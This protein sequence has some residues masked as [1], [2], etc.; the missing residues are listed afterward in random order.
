M[1]ASP[2]VAG[3]DT[4]KLIGI[5]ARQTVAPRVLSIRGFLTPHALGTLWGGTFL[6]LSGLF[7]A[8]LLVRVLD[9]N[10]ANA[11]FLMLSAAV[12]LNVFSDFGQRNT[13]YTDVAGLRDEPLREYIRSTYVRRFALGLAVF[14]MAVGLA[15]VLHVNTLLTTIL[16]AIMAANSYV[17]DPGIKILCG[18]SLGYLEVPLSAIDRVLVLAGLL[19]M[20]LI[21]SASLDLVLGLYVVAGLLRF[22]GAATAVR[23]KILGQESS[24]SVSSRVKTSASS[25]ACHNQPM[26]FRRNHFWAGI[27]LLVT[28]LNLRLPVLVLPLVN[29]EHHAAHMGILMALCQSVL[30]V[31]TVVSRVWFPQILQ[32]TNGTRQLQAL[33]TSQMLF[34]CLALCLAAGLLATIV[35]CT[36][37]PHI[38]KILH[39][40][41]AARPELLRLAAIAI[42]LLC[43]GQIGRLLATSAGVARNLFLPVATGTV[44]GLLSMFFLAQT[45]GLPGII[46][47]GLI[48]EFVVFSLTMT[49]VFKQKTIADAL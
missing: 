35:L 2:P 3:E 24:D 44:V 29:L 6:P 46:Y 15:Y 13:I 47:G 7:C 30:F 23:R 28:L 31:P 14:G 36:F 25:K 16:F 48:S 5:S 39:P 45:R 12:V 22:I 27:L 17:A 8:I 1:D 21:G 37:A 9:S 34:K 20:L 11:F 43:A 19:T 41:Y 42:P 40:S 32:S 4:R 33:L 38:L 18:K 10:N 49:V 26:G